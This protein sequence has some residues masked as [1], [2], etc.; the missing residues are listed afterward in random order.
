VLQLLVGDDGS[1]NIKFV[2]F[3]G[4]TDNR[5]RNPRGVTT[6]WTGEKE[7]VLVAGSEWRYSYELEGSYVRSYGTG[8]DCG[9][10]LDEKSLLGWVP[11]RHHHLADNERGCYC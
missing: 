5:L 1:V 6:R 11:L 3:I 8:E 7:L 9:H 2:R 4:A 10:A